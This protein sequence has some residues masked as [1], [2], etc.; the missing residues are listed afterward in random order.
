MALKKRYLLILSV[1]LVVLTMSYVS[2]SD[3]TTDLVKEC[4]DGMISINQQESD[5]ISSSN[6]DESVGVIIENN[7]SSINETNEC[8]VLAITNDSDILSVS[9]SDNV[10]TSSVSVSSSY[11]EPTKKQRTFNIGGFKAVLTKA[12]YKKLY[13]ISSIEDK[14]FDEGY[15]DYYY[16]GEKF[17]GYG[18]SSTGLWYTV[19]VKTNKFIKV[20]VKVGNKIKYKKTR[21]YMFFAYGAGQCGV[22][23][24]HMVF[25]THNYNNPGYDYSKVMGKNYKYFTK[26]KHNKN[27]VKLNKS[28]LTSID[29]VYKHYYVY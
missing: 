1:V 27:F 16:V 18:I 23:Y 10:L 13:Q 6:S 3:N 2:A 26:C 4:D 21:A 28:K 5:N 29:Y 14:F 19:K 15:D 8:E 17:R 12:Q 25:L 24:R 22:A 20:K 11:K 7:Y 9:S